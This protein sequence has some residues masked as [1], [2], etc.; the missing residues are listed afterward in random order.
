MLLLL[1]GCALPFAAP[2]TP[3]ATF[4]PVPTSM[5]TPTLP[6]V[7]IEEIN[8]EN[9]D[10]AGRANLNFASFPAGAVLPPAPIAGS[11]RGVQLVLDADTV[12]SGELYRLG[13]DLQAGILMLGADLSA[14]GDLPLQLAG[15]D[16]VVLSLKTNSLTRA[17]HVE[18]MLQSLIAIPGVD[19]GAIGIVGESEAAD[20]ALLA[21]AVNSLCDA[22]A[23][24][25]PR[26][27]DTLVNM[28]P[29]LGERPL[30]LAASTSDTESYTAALALKE[31]ALGEAELLE[32][33]E[34]SGANMLQAQPEL[35]AHLVEWL[36]IRLH[37]N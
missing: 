31:A 25:S 23:L 11:E 32:V 21:C 24:L 33:G 19:A 18:T 5:P 36:S 8:A 10:S 35:G 12:I 17:R 27:G 4:T 30:W 1:T 2:P 34:G 14:W 6:Q 37:G 13:A 20:L 29:S 28:L 26:S 3:I 15:A 9:Q 16:F 22:L 7:Y